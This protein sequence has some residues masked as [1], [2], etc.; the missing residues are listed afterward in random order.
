MK[1]NRIL[2]TLL[3]L[4]SPMLV[5]AAG[6]VNGEPFLYSMWGIG[7]IVILFGI[8]ALIRS[9]AAQN[10]LQTAG[11]ASGGY[12]SSSAHQ[13]TTGNDAVVRATSSEGVSGSDYSGGNDIFDDEKDLLLSHSYDG[14]QELNNKLPPWWVG[15]FYVTIIFAVIYFPYY[16]IFS[17]WTSAKEYETE[18]ATAKAATDAYVKEHGGSVTEEDVTVL[19]DE[20][21]LAA[22][23]KTFATNCV[24]CHAADGGGGVGPNLTD[25]YWLHGGGIKD[26]FKTIKYGVPEKGMIAWKASLSPVQIQQVASF[27]EKKLQG[28]TP[29][30]PKDPQGEEY[31]GE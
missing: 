7:A 4:L 9:N 18:M 10:E 1:N 17:G 26:V 21:S 31:T 13:A 12:S 19:T 5:F 14:I 20:A 27:I 11:A 23:A 28:T 30:K 6:S 8:Y 25:K 3:S 22:G 15:L 16:H 24:A 2:F 29:A